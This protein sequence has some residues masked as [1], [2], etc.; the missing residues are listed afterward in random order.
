MK[1]INYQQRA[2][3]FDKAIR[4]VRQTAAAKKWSDRR[5]MQQEKLT[6]A[7][8][9]EKFTLAL[10]AQPDF[11][12]EDYASDDVAVMLT[13]VSR[14]A[15]YQ[16]QDDKFCEEKRL[17]FAAEAYER[18][19]NFDADPQT[20]N[21]EHELKG[22]SDLVGALK[23]IVTKNSL[24]FLNNVEKKLQER[25]SEQQK[26]A[27]PA[28]SKE[29]NAA[30][31][32]RPSNP[33]RVS[34][35]VSAEPR[36]QNSDTTFQ[37]LTP[38][39]SQDENIAAASG[40]APQTNPSSVQGDEVKNADLPP[41]DRDVR[42][43][44]AVSAPQS[45][46]E[47]RAVQLLNLAE[48]SNIIISS[49]DAQPAQFPRHFDFYETE[50]K[51]DS[52]ESNGSLTMKN[53]NEVSLNSTE[54][55]HYFLTAQLAVNTGHDSLELGPLDENNPADMKFAAD[56]VVAG[57][58]YGLEVSDA[59][60]L[61]K[62]QEYNPKIK[63]LIEKRQIRAE[64][65]QLRQALKEAQA[66]G[67]TEEIARAEAAVQNKIKDALQKHIENGSIDERK[68]SADKAADRQKRLDRLHRIV[69]KS[70]KTQPSDK[71]SSPHKEALSLNAMKELVR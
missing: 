48:K 56:M 46:P 31:K 32:H 36:R 43:E 20:Y 59:P 14:G 67:N 3:E 5:L 65:T 71:P 1:E 68:D 9:T 52:G 18:L 42:P 26:S 47:K 49:S 17:E 25:L 54:M 70:S 10:A 64:M 69:D 21:D 35:A 4:A 41:Q 63:L 22:L 19:K 29:A 2:K 27:Q 39:V 38:P 34:R 53:E 40:N 30:G 45:L 15:V 33:F 13:D 37:P 57:A 61:E 66:S 55:Q 50:A 58:V 62:L 7:A 12:I 23:K 11:R 44:Q 6:A 16:G 8:V 28:T 60:E 24:K 51:K